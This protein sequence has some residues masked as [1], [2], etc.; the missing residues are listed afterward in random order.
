MDNRS[1][2]ETALSERYRIELE[3]G[4]G[5]MATVYRALDLKHDRQVAVK[6]LDSELALYLGAE[7]FLQEIKLAANL[8]HPHI[9][10]V[11]DSG[12]ANGYLYFVMPFVAGE[13]LRS[14]LDRERQLPV[15]DVLRISGE[16][17]D[18]LAYAH[19]QGV[20]HRDVKPA[21]I[22]LEAGHAVLADFGVAHAVAEAKEERLTKPG[23]SLGTPAY[24]SPEQATG[25]HALDGRS[26]QYALACVL[27]EML[28]GDPPFTGSTSGAVLARQIHER[29]PSLT[30]VRPNLPPGLV[31]A[32]EKALAKV[33]ADRFRSTSEFHAALEKG[34]GAR[35]GASPRSWS[36]RR[37]A[38]SVG[39]GVLIA[40]L[41][42]A[43]LWLF[44]PRAPLDEN[45]VTLFPLDVSGGV[46]AEESGRGEDNAYI[47]WNALEGRG[48]LGWINAL[49]LVE[50]SAEASRMST[51]QRRALAM[52]NGSGHY[53]QGRLMFFGDSARAF[54]TL[55]EVATD[56]VV[57]R[58][59]TAGPREEAALLGVRVISRL[60]LAFMPEQT[61][62]VSAVAGRDPQPV[63][64]FLQGERA[65]HAGR[66]REA[67]RHYSEA[68]S[69]DSSFAL[70]AVKGAQAASWL[71]ASDEAEDLIHVA[72][73][74]EDSLTPRAYHFARGMEA[75]LASQA[76]SAVLH[77]EAAIALDPTW[78]EAW[79][80]LG[81]TYTHLLPRRAPQDSLAKAA[82]LQV[83]RETNH[84]APALFHLVE[85]TIR[86]GDLRRAEG[87]LEEYRAASPDTAGYGTEKL[88]RMRR[89]STAGPEDIDWEERVLRDVAHVLEAARALGVGGAYLR[90]AEAGY[91]AVLSFDTSSSAGWRY[92]ASVG[93]QSALAAQGEVSQLSAFLDT[94]SAFSANLRPHYIVDALAGIPVEPQAEREAQR[95][96]EDVEGLNDWE[97]W[98]LGTWDAQRGSLQEARMLSDRLGDRA[99]RTEARR[100]ELVAASL[101]A[102]VA[103]AAGDTTAAMTLLADLTPNERRGSLYNPWESLGVE[104]LL[105]ARILLAEGQ[106][107]RA[108]QEA[109]VF[110]SPGAANLI[111][112]TFLPASLEIRLE[113]ARR[114]GDQ[115][116]VEIMQARLAALAGGGAR[117]R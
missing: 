66:F 101:R 65:F 16:I 7:R 73:D 22:L 86:D 76:D 44:V 117:I 26:D 68:V 93:L 97:T 102:H 84:S 115:H 56:S 36:R 98:Y 4:R 106:Y 40:C 80:G 12:R 74:H 41:V 52:A 51:R 92:A 42:A 18:A 31:G 38:W 9:L 15:E 110:D 37:L 57:A 53:L 19:S 107:A 35:V 30:V 25:D 1:R 108:Y 96:R 54:L 88:A 60:F 48:S 83:Y 8:T 21:N 46:T 113:A 6:V 28:T 13:S 24:M 10:P 90:C 81:E 39:G 5:G 105:L 33:P 103:L 58:A 11:F 75:F 23:T 55:H 114:L 34:M 14:R 78:P 77:F 45:L 79:T 82:F 91:R 94:V 32:I 70:A 111:F 50:N 49:N 109:S 63:Q 100:A 59:D 67:L 20:I 87:L 43:Y 85:S 17:A 47:I 27:Y 61:V 64:I 112:P 72:L 2:L 95:L 116:A 89:C 99:R 104:R 29:P 3:I 71:H 69:Q 62:D